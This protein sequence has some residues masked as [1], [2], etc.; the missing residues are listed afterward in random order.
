MSDRVQEFYQKLKELQEPKGFYFNN[1]EKMVMELL[2]NLLVNKDRYGYT[3]CP[4][5][6]AA[7]KYELDK[8]IIC[9]CVYA[10]QD[11]EEYGSCYCGLYVS[12]DWNQDKIEHVFVPERRPPEKTMAALENI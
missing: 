9:P 6:L 2:N 5:R 1:D 3:A 10:K 11:I 8:D 4:C 7:G 12:R